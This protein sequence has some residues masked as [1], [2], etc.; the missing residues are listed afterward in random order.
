ML[1]AI[2]S[3]ALAGYSLAVTR[4]NS[5][6]LSRQF[7]YLNFPNKDHIPLVVSALQHIPF[8]I[9]ASG[10]LL[11]SL[12]VLPQNGRYWKV[13]GKA[14]NRTRQWSI[15]VAMNILWVFVAFL[16]TIV[17]SF[18]D[19]HN[20]IT[21][22]GDA[23]YSV[24]TVWTYLLPLV[25]GWLHVGCQ[26][27]ADHLRSALDDA[28]DIAYV[29]TTAGP[30]LATRITGRSTRAIEPSTKHVDHVNADE[31]K[32]TPIFNY[33]RVF[34]W[35]QNAE[36]VL[37]LYENAASKADR[38]KTVHMGGV[39]MSN[40]DDRVG[41][42]MEVV[43]YCTTEP[44]PSAVPLLIAEMNGNTDADANRCCP[45]ASSKDVE[46]TMPAEVRAASEKPVFATEVFLRVVFAT[47]LALG[48]QWGTTGASIL[49]H[50]NTPPKGLG[51]RALTFIL[52]GAAATVAFF[53]LLFSSIVSHLVRP[54]SAR[55]K[56]SGLKTSIG[57]IATLTRWLGKFIAIMNGFGILLSC[58]MLFAG[59]Y[60]NCFCTSTT[61]VGDTNRLVSFIEKDI[62]GSEVYRYWI[63]GIVMAFG[64]SG[65]YTFAIYVATPMG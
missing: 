20:F 10:S 50:L 15:P 7:T 19:F 29:A 41:N 35:S 47:L 33:S 12:I 23:G 2:G 55:K 62:K 42:E 4:L 59:V 52:Y 1:L 54:Q 6:W 60:D 37:R 24:A 36:H 16:L 30:V 48:L 40:D 18:V 3:P 57:Y 22:P 61:F 8:R 17:D 56:R 28:Q 21:V 44:E 13:L 63:G 26:P 58:L 49:I 32:T 53:L 46:E 25:I 34:F 39:W 38:K 31:K 45:S 5:R 27:D 51:C 14:A 9:N 11:P 43:Q 65:L 64:M